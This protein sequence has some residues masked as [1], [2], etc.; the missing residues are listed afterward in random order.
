[1]DIKK[2]LEKLEKHFMSIDKTTLLEKLEGCGLGKL[3][4]SEY[5]GGYLTP[6]NVF[7][8]DYEILELREFYKNYAK[9]LRPFYKKRRKPVVL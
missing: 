5:Y 2:E 3:K 7:F 8:Y 9:V 1:M 4:G 6:P